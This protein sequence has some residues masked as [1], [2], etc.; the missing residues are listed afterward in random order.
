MGIV[1]LIT[2]LIYGGVIGYS[3]IPSLMWRLLLPM[4]SQDIY[5]GNRRNK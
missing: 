5:D 2:L 4:F 3:T 1:W